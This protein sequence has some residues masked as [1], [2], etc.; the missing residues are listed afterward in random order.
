VRP[1]REV[2]PDWTGCQQSEA[3][4][5]VA[6]TSCFRLRLRGLTDRSHR[7]LALP[8]SVA[9]SGHAAI[10]FVLH[11]RVGPSPHKPELTW[12]QVSFSGCL[13]HPHTHRCF[14]RVKATASPIV[15]I[16][17]PSRA[18]SRSTASSGSREREGSHLAPT[19]P[20]GSAL[21][22]ASHKPVI[23]ESPLLSLSCATRAE[24]VR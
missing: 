10:P 17:F 12:W 2:Q 15:G 11:A 5:A 13:H 8:S 7:W 9:A 21:I 16:V 23:D 14:D 3:E 1:S 6:D 18:S 24:C 19:D 20:D 4:P 22:V